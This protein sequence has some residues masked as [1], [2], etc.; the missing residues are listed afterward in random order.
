MKS[1]AFLTTKPK[2]S[3]RITDGIFV[4]DELKSNRYALSS[5]EQ[6]AIM[7]AAVMFEFK[8][9]VRTRLTNLTQALFD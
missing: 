4:L 7:I 8:L 5:K 3:K 1:V 2:T 6:N 9:A